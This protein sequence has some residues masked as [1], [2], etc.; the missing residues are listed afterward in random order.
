VGFAA[1][2]ARALR[3]PDLLGSLTRKSPSALELPR[4]EINDICLL[5]IEK[6]WENPSLREIREPIKKRQSKT[7]RQRESIGRVSLM[8][9]NSLWNLLNGSPDFVLSCEQVN[10]FMRVQFSSGIFL[11]GE[12]DGIFLYM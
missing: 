12:E 7:D 4:G 2:L 3:A 5:Y 8:S 9:I 1:L 11:M 10:L 6:I